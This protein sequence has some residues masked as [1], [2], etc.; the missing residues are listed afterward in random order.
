MSF[1]AIRGSK[2]YMEEIKSAKKVLI[3]HIDNLKT[4]KIDLNRE[5][6]KTDQI[7]SKIDYENRI[8]E[9]SKELQEFQGMFR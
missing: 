9:I 1:T 6:R 8:S 5:L 2:S 4:E 3:D 7:Q